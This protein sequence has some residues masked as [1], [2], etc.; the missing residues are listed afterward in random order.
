M[1]NTRTCRVCGCT[2]E[3]CSGC[4]KKT[5]QP[6]YWV[7]TDLCSACVPEATAPP[8]GLRLQIEPTG[9][10]LVID[11]VPC[12]VWNGTRDDG[13]PCLVFVHRV[14][15][16]EAGDLPGTAPVAMPLSVAPINGPDR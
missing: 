8:A 6:C 12:R 11:G 1:T 14:V 13:T 5:G 16:W 2:D 15:V 10:T 7:A 4:V 9:T 3:D